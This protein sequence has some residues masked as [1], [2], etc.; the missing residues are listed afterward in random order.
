[1]K[2]VFGSALRSDWGRFRSSVLPAWFCWV[3][4]ILVT[5]FLC[6][7]LLW[8]SGVCFFFVYFLSVH[9]FSNP[10]WMKPRPLRYDDC[11][12]GCIP[13]ETAAP[14]AAAPDAW[15]WFPQERSCWGEKIKKWWMLPSL[16]CSGQVNAASIKSRLGVYFKR[17]RVESRFWDTWNA[18]RPFW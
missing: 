2:A 17:S 13:V 4:Q 14:P 16:I 12:S 1:M 7:L 3:A 10:V 6:L 5:F 8:V 18:L 9:C 11:L 15:T